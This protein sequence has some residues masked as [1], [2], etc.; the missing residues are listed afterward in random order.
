MAIPIVPLA[1]GAWRV[2]NLA[3]NVLFAG[4]LA[5]KGIKHFKNKTRSDLAIIILAAGKGTR[6]K[7]NTAKVLHKVGDKE[8]ILRVLDTATQLSD[9]ITV[10]VGH[11]AEKVRGVIDPV[12][13]VNYAF[14]DAQL[15]TGHAVKIALPYIPENT[16]NVLILYGDVP[17]IQPSTLNAFIDFHNSFESDITILGTYLKD[18]TGYGRL[19]TKNDR[20]VSKII[21]DIDT[22][23]E[24]KKIDLINTG[25][26]CVKLSVLENTLKYVKPNNNKGEYYLTDIA[27]VGNTLNHKVIT[28]R[29]SSLSANEVLGVN[30][31]QELR[32]ANEFTK[33]HGSK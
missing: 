19:I 9:N 18:P 6:M 3:G 29:M 10:V 11:Q 27:A 28:Y 31:I 25:I 12:F 20:F 7:S 32:A 30:T 1:L 24:T 4:H 8:M 15:G 13:K 14:Q 22:D 26:Y 23:N 17:L 2:I 21:E 16:E 33:N 5:L